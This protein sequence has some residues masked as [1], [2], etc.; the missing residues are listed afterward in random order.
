MTQRFT[1]VLAVLHK[2][3]VDGRQLGEPG[4][5]TLTRDLPLPLR[6]VTDHAGL[7]GYV[8]RVW[9]DG[10]LLCYSGALLPTDDG[11]ADAIRAGELVGMLDADRVERMEQRYRGRTVP[12]SDLDSIPPD[13]DP[14]DL[15]TVLHGWRVMAVTLLPPEGKAWPEISLAVRGH[16]EDR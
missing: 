1:G 13:A 7:V 15:L 5:H 11:T 16:A 2:R 10:D 8:T 3:S 9:R 6:R 12:D 14:A 4:P